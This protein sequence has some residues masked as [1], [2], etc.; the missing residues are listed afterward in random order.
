[1]VGEST[2]VSTPKKVQPPMV[3][4]HSPRKRK[5]SM[6]FSRQSNNNDSDP[7]KPRGR[8]QK[9]HPDIS[10]G[11]CTVWLQM[12]GPED[13]KADHTPKSGQKMEHPGFNYPQWNEWLLKEGLVIDINYDSCI[14]P[15][16]A[17]DCRKQAKD[18]PRYFY[19][20]QHPQLTPKHCFVCD[21]ET[22][23]NCEC[24]S[25]QRWSPLWKNMLN[26]GILEMFLSSRFGTLLDLHSPNDY[27]VCK[28]HFQQCQRYE[29]GI[30]CSVCNT[31]H[32]TTWIAVKGMG[33]DI[34]M[35]FK[36]AGISMHKDALSYHDWMCDE[37]SGLYV[38]A[39]KTKSSSSLED[40]AQSQDKQTRFFAKSVMEGL[41][42]MRKSGYL[43]LSEIVNQYQRF[44][45][46]EHL[47]CT[48]KVLNKC[49]SY[50]HRRLREKEVPTYYNDTTNLGTMIYDQHILS[51]EAAM[52]IYDLQSQLQCEKETNKNLRQGTF[53]Y[54]EITT[55]LRSHAKSC[56]VNFRSL[57]KNVKNKY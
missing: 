31:S 52:I 47:P 4:R 30:K 38:R 43:F 25:I 8:P 11:D 22:P 6:F 37:C 40:D 56:K 15:G 9:Y 21:L 12:G 19:Q 42:E 1:M 54:S 34:T 39:A 5:T 41:D 33:D 32:A 57:F 48:K 50:A 16:C 53:S 46:T 35:L 18:K 27:S 10:C 51:K 26:I 45:S 3:S 23:Q 20:L 7:K 36:K 29:A 13:V 55:L 44:A 28:R 24:A 17:I 14:C 2:N 49:R